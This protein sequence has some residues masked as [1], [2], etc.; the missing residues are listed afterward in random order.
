[1]AE[2]S[3]ARWRSV[4]K[5]QTGTMALAAARIEHG[6]YGYEPGYGYAMMGGG[7]MGGYGGPGNRGNESPWYKPPQTGKELTENDAKT[8]VESYLSGLTNPNLRIGNIKDMGS[9]FE[10][11]VVTKDGSLVDKVDVDKNTGYMNSIY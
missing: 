4:R 10:V 1:M 11:E 3:P 8:E 6:C 9:A 5:M 7:M 2:V